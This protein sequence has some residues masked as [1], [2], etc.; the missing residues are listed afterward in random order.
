VE[1]TGGEL[2]GFVP[3]ELAAEIAPRRRRRAV[4]RGRSARA[5]GHAAWPADRRHDASRAGQGA[6]P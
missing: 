6:P 2:L 1:T 4:Q 5:A 3:R